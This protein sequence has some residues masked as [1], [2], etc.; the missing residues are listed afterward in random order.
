VGYHILEAFFGAPV[1][2]VLIIEPYFFRSDELL[3]RPSSREPAAFPQLALGISARGE[4]FK[5][6]KAHFGILVPLKHRVYGFRKFGATAL[7]YATGVDPD[8]VEVPT[9]S[10]AS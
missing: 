4:I 9:S 3:K 8:V 5:V 10:E 7:V 6:S 1:L 2:P